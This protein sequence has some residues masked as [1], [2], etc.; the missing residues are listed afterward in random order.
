MPVLR[1]LTSRDLELQAHTTVPCLWAAGESPQS[2][3]ANASPI[4]FKSHMNIF[5]RF[6]VRTENQNGAEGKKNFPRRTVPW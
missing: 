5:S 2:W 3:Q 6:K 4:E 1:D